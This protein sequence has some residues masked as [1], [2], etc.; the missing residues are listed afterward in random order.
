[1]YGYTLKSK[2]TIMSFTAVATVVIS[3]HI[4]KRSGCATQT[5]FFRR[6]LKRQ[7]KRKQQDP[8]RNGLS[9]NRAV[10]R[11]KALK[12][13]KVCSWVGMGK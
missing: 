12:M 4:S 1:M 2:H 6:A 7:T 11:R 10:K 8:F 3:H 13:Q 9:Y 5:D